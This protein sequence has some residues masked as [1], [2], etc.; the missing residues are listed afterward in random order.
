MSLK[1]FKEYFANMNLW[2]NKCNSQIELLNTI[3]LPPKNIVCLVI[4]GN[5][6]YVYRHTG[7]EIMDRDNTNDKEYIVGFNG[8][9]IR[10]SSSGLIAAT[11]SDNIGNGIEGNKILSYHLRLAI[12]CYFDCRI[13]TDLSNIPQSTT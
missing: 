5:C 1:T 11:R 12:S 2:V 6:I 8:S 4:L 3:E 7:I 10:V 9:I 13:V